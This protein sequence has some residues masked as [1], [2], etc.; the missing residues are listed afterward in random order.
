MTSSGVITLYTL[1]N[2]KG[3]V[4]KLSSLGAG[5]ISV[6][7]PDKNGE[8]ADVALGYENVED[9][10][11]DGPCAGK[12]PGRYAN[13]IGKGRFSIDGVEY[14]LAV[15]NG[16]NHLHG[17]PEGFQN[18]LWDSQ[19]ID[20]RVVFFRRSPDGE[21]NYPGNLDV[22][23]IYS[24]DDSCRLR[25]DYEA[26]TDSKTIVNLTNHTYFNL[27]GHGKGSV[28][29]HTLWLNCSRYLP[30][31]ETLVPVGTMAP[32]AGTPMD[33]TVEKAL[34]SD[35]NTDFPALKYGK[36]YDN[37]WVVDGYEEKALKPVARL[38]DNESGRVLEISSTQP[39]AQV[40]TGNWLTGSPVGKDGVEYHDYDCVAIECQGMPDAPNKAAFPSQQLNP[41]E[42]YRHTIEFL[43]KN[44]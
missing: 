26:M 8:M 41:G 1:T 9:Y 24:W 27:S 43:F 32:V 37:C 36:G 5:I 40:Y 3:A 39:A 22:R 13:R 20:G 34:G 44:L 18:K 15:N 38:V 19:I 35:I 25:I 28:L 42:I 21:E 33:F 2:S 29:G 17:G 7:V 12:T 14:Q 11:H 31:D 30:T 23:V 6:V 10:M 4:V 16:P